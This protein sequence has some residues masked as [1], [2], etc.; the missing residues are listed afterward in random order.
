MSISK[1]QRYPPLSPIS[2]IPLADNDAG[3]T[4]DS[5]EILGF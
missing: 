2:T 3:L 5:V 4:G 1:R